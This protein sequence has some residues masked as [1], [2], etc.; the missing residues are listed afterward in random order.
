MSLPVVVLSA[1]GLETGHDTARAEEPHVEPVLAPLHAVIAVQRR[2]EGQSFYVKRSPTMQN[3][4]N[5]WSLLSIQFRPEEL[6]DPFDFSTVERFM[7]RLSDE[8]LGGVSPRV[9]RYLTSG[10][11]SRNPINRRVTLH[12]YE[13]ALEAEPRLNPAYYVDGA[14][15][16]PEQYESRAAGSQCGLCLRLWSDYCYRN[17]LAARRFA[18]VP[19]LDATM[20]I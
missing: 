17:G 9:L 20:L 15:L 12:L 14:W 7:Q 2:S 19:D 13:I 18:P 1:V 5:V 8:R 11:C 6:P 16:M 10:T 4:P 3:Y